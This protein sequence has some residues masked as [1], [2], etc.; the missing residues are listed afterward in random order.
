V[1]RDLM[2]SE[3]IKSLVRE[4]YGSIDADTSSVA[5]K[6]YD[7]DQLAFVPETAR[8]RA[9]GVGNHLRFA[10]IRAGESVLDLG[11]G[12]G[13]D[14]II[15]AHQTG[16]TGKVV[17]LDFLEE[18]VERTSKAAAEASLDNVEALEGE[19]ESIPL[20]DDS[21]DLIISNGVINLSPRKARVLA[22]CARVLRSGGKF[23][24][25]DLTVNEGDLPPEILTH[26]AAWAG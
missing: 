10:D 19:M 24:V 22:E 11:C 2:H 4:A 15:A 3:E 5:A 1:S 21:V 13:I 9:L 14:A 8:S 17:G 16:P 25:S 18:M 20:P 23:C 12:G 7:P 26:P 6:L